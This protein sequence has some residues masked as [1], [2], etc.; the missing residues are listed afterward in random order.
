MTIQKGWI[1]VLIAALPVL[2]GAENVFQL[3]FRGQARFL[4]DN[5]R[6]QTRR[7]TTDDLIARCVG[8]AGLGTN[9]HGTNRQFELVY[10]PAVDGV[11]VIDLT[12]GSFVCD[13][14][15]F[16]AGI[17]NVANREKSRLAFVFVPDQNEAV[18]SAVISEKVR[19][20][21]SFR[22]LHAQA[23]FALQN[24]ELGSTAGAQFTTSPGVETN[25][26]ATNGLGSGGSNLGGSS[27]GS[28]ANSGSSGTN[29]G[30]AGTNVTGVVPT[31]ALPVTSPT[32]PVAPPV[33]T[34][35]TLIVTN[36]LSGGNAGITNSLI[37]SPPALP[38]TSSTVSG[39]ATNVLG[40]D[41][42]NGVISIG[43]SATNSPALPISPGL[44]TTNSL[45]GFS[46]ATG[47]PT[48]PEVGS[49]ATGAAANEAGL[50][51]TNGVVCTGTF[52]TGRRITVN[53]E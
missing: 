15:Q 49:G 30:T 28:G 3:S 46:A 32:V 37:L 36:N 38:G 23:Q 6:I 9:N 8:E 14:L 47:V 41:V 43:G 40:T 10:N 31:N 18:G 27:S 25:N 44:N 12:N 48:S 51:I 4:N 26:T 39:G 13:V 7:L 52:S 33:P 17:S 29:S 53:S 19:N 50:S 11:Q 16:Q 5:G 22:S 21:G 1:T 20:G 35:S 45:V 34:N 24:L 42:T 2:A